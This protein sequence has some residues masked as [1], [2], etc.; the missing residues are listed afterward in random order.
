V[1]FQVTVNETL[2]MEIVQTQQYLEDD[3]GS[4]ILIEGTMLTKVA[5]QILS[6][7]AILEHEE[8]RVV[9]ERSTELRKVFRLNI[10]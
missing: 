8:I 5:I 10:L 9:L 4:R 7:H 2:L 3:I 6:E 1:R